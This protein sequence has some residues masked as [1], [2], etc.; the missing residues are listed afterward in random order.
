M[1][2]KALVLECD[3]PKTTFVL[4][5]DLYEF[6][7]M[8]FGLIVGAHKMPISCANIASECMK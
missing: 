1:V 4:R 3:I 6:M 5:Y 8:S 7:I 2:N